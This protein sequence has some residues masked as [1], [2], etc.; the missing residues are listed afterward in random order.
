MKQRIGKRYLA[1]THDFYL[2][3]TPGRQKPELIMKA[4]KLL[5]NAVISGGKQTLQDVLRIKDYWCDLS[6]H[7]LPNKKNE[8]AC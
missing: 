2:K 8:I 5:A 3:E 1:R 4:D 6:S 7:T